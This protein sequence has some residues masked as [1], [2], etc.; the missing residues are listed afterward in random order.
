MGDLN[1]AVPSNKKI[2]ELQ[3][4]LDSIKGYLTGPKFLTDQTSQKYPKD[5]GAYY[6][7]TVEDKES[8]IKYLE[9]TIA[10][11]SNELQ[12][13][14]TPHELVKQKVVQKVQNLP[15][16]N[17]EMTNEFIANSYY[18]PV[19][20]NNSTDVDI[21]NNTNKSQSMSDSIIASRKSAVANTVANTNQVLKK[22]EIVQKLQKTD[23]NASKT[24][25]EADA[26]N[27]G[28]L[29]NNSA[30]GFKPVAEI[31]KMTTP[32]VENKKVESKVEKTDESK[33]LKTSK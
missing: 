25:V 10:R 15:N 19:P 26:V 24:T 18:Y 9:E 1:D 7:P 16:Y 8:R 5:A 17:K 12:H 4:E 23:L 13:P 6:D 32:L 30:T 33:N 22:P 21:P 31:P 20:R 27:N 14:F 28:S 3:Q 29:V 2:Q 11:L